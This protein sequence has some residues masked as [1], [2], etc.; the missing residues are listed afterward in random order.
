MINNI[1]II[2]IGSNIELI[3]FVQGVPGKIFGEIFQQ[4]DALY[5]FRYS[6]FNMSRERYF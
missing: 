4:T 6:R 3:Y 5:C 2:Q 1:T